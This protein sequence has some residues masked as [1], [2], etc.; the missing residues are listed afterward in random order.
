VEDV[1]VRAL[2]AAITLGRVLLLPCQELFIGISL[3]CSITWWV[4][5]QMCEWLRVVWGEKRLLLLNSAQIREAQ[6]LC[7]CLTLDQKH[8]CRSWSSTSLPLTHPYLAVHHWRATLVAVSMYTPR[9]LKPSQ[10]GPGTG[11]CARSAIGFLGTTLLAAV[12][13]RGVAAPSM[14][15]VVWSLVLLRALN[16]FLRCRFTAGNSRVWFVAGCCCCC[17]LCCGLLLLVLAWLAALLPGSVSDD[18]SVTGSCA[19]QG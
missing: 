12:G 10:A 7:Q 2:R 6:S 3:R 1:A 18:S 9:T 17:W 16:Q 14:R 15:A 8:G 13:V 11:G 4:C 5:V 19:V